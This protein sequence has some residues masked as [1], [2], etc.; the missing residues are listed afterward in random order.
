GEVSAAPPKVAPPGAQKIDDFAK[1]VGTPVPPD[2]IAPPLDMVI[3]P[4]PPS[5]RSLLPFL[6]AL[7]LAIL[8]F[9]IV[10]PAVAIAIAVVL[11]AI[12]VFLFRRSRRADLARAAA[13]V[14]AR[15]AETV[16]T[17]APPASAIDDIPPSP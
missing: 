16:S 11:F 15:A 17:L 6:I 7:I 1:A 10:S 14:A 9:L 12:A 3:D 4:G 5:L 2:T 8:L 13:N